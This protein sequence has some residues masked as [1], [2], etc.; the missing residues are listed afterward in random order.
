MT[1][2]LSSA[3]APS[4][5]IKLLVIFPLRK[6]V[7]STAD[8]GENADGLIANAACVASGYIAEILDKHSIAGFVNVER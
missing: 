7:D 6:I 5:R 3:K 8:E 2:I 4:K 1:A